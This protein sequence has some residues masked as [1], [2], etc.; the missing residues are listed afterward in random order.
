MERLT[1][2]KLL[3]PRY[4]LIALYPQ[5][6]WELG[7]ILIVESDGE[8]YSPIGGYVQSKYI[9]KEKEALKYNSIFKLLD[10][11]MD[12]K[13]EELPEYVKYPSGRIIK[14]KWEWSAQERCYLAYNG[15][16]NFELMPSSEKEY[17]DFK[18]NT[19]H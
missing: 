6:Q 11:W 19:N 1:A 18:I 16:S 9:V 2:E 5:C 14:P 13:I 17:S 8:L 12:R 3:K 4:K 10:W 15:F 7:E